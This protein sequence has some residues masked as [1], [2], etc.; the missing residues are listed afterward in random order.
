MTPLLL[1]EDDKEMCSLLEEYLSSEGFQVHIANDGASGLREALTGEYKIILLDVM[2]PEKNGFDV[3]RELRTQSLVPVIML[4]ARGEDI[5]RIV[6]LEMGADDYLPKP[7]NPRELV[8]R[9]KALLRRLP[10][11]EPE[12]NL[13]NS[14][15]VKIGPI[16]LNDSSY[17]AFYNDQELKLTNT[18]YTILKLLIMSP[19]KVITKQALSKSALD[20]NHGEFDRSIDMHVSNIRRK[21]KAFGA[22]GNIIKTVRGVG[23]LYQI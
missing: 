2:L 23:Y 9:V 20:R 16:S 5:D 7:F 11:A 22:D 18:E 12:Q 8:A 13:S 21:L 1:I 4:T 6:G 10:Q 17:Q 19:D 15:S 3:L 14:N